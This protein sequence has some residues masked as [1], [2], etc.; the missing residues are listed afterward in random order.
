MLLVCK[1]RV[2]QELFQALFCHRCQGKKRVI[3]W[4][5][6]QDLVRK[7]LLFQVPLQWVEIVGKQKGHLASTFL[8]N[9]H[10]YS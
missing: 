4:M 2:E 5:L 1:G 6:P 9:S 3:H 7:V 8:T 10:M